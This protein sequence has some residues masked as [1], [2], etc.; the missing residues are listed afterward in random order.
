MVIAHTGIKVPAADIVAAVKFYEAALAPLGYKKTAV[1]LNGLVNGFDD[2]GSH[3]A[4]WYVSAAQEGTP[5]KSH[6]C[7]VAKDR[8]TVDAFYKVALEAGGK[9][10][11]APGVRAHYHKDYYAAFVLDAVGN[12]IEVVYLGPA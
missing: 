12:N 5:V 7:F 9:D 3:G 6:H 1:Y 4:D 11:G 8:A 2:G 10:N